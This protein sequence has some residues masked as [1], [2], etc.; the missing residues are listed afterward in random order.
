MKDDTSSKIR[1]MNHQRMQ[2]LFATIG[3]SQ[4]YASYECFLSLKMSE[5]RKELENIQK[6]NQ[7]IFRN[8][9]S[10]FSSGMILSSP[11]YRLIEIFPVKTWIFDFIPTFRCFQN[12]HFN[13]I[14]WSFRFE[15][16]VD[17]TLL[18]FE[19]YFTSERF[20]PMQLQ[21]SML[22]NKSLMNRLKWIKKAV[23]AQRTQLSLK[24]E[25]LSFPCLLCSFII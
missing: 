12:I 9:G 14:M 16:T 10:E 21:I 4:I 24:P 8:L 11:C 25:F 22:I 15:S 1:H 17:A 7:E 5:T 23:W 13:S 3:T 18:A 2:L 19:G 6:C 20:Y